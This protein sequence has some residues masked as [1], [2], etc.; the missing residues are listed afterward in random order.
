M[1]LDG[2]R[3]PDQ[4]MHVAICMMLK[5]GRLSEREREGQWKEAE[6]EEGEEEEVK[7]RHTIHPQALNP[8][9]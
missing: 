5:F 4:H 1:H 8:I 3:C 7:C 9:T 2:Q 6:I